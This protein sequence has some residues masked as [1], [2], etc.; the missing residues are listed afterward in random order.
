MNFEDYK[1]KFN[2]AL[3]DEIKI[4]QKNG[5]IENIFG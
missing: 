1:D 5:G 2:Q 3:E 4:L